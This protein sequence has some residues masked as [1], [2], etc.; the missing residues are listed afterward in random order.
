[1]AVAVVGHTSRFV[2]VGVDV[3]PNL[4]LPDGVAKQISSQ[5]ESDRLPFKGPVCWD[6]LLFC[7][8]EAIYKVWFPIERRWLGFDDVTVVIDPARQTF[9]ATL[10]DEGIIINEQRV[11]ELCGHF[12]ASSSHLFTIV[13]IP[14]LPLPR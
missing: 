7:S 1:M 11:T 4:P 9:T 12:A 8:K 6:R 3:E 13:A 2:S 14:P 5:F 10:P